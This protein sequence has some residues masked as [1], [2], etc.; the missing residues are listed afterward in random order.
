MELDTE[1]VNKLT[2]FID[3]SK[4]H[5]DYELEV[6]LMGKNFQKVEIDYE[7]YLR[8]FRKLTYSTDKN[9]LGLEY[10]IVQILDII[11]QSESNSSS[12]FD[13]IR[14]SI[15]GQD[16]I[17]KYWLLDDL[18]KC[19]ESKIKMIEKE[20]LDKIDERNYHVR[21][22]LNRE[23]DESEI[24]Q[25]NKNLIMNKNISKDVIKT[26]RLKNRYS[27][28]TSDGLFSIDMTAIKTGRGKNLKESNTMKSIPQFEIEIEFIGKDSSLDNRDICY[29]CI[30]YTS[31]LLST[32]QN[33]ENIIK[34][35]TVDLILQKY[36]QLVNRRRDRNHPENLD[37]IA[38]N[39]VTFHRSNLIQDPVRINIY[40]NYAVTLKA[41]GER[42]L[43]Y[44]LPSDNENENGKMYLFDTN[45]RM[46]DTG[47]KNTFWNDTLIEGEL[48]KIENRY[49]FFAYDMLF[50]RGNDIRNQ[51]LTEMRTKDTKKRDDTRVYTRLGSLRNFVNPTHM[52]YSEN[53]N[54]NNCI[55]IQMKPYRFLF[56]EKGREENIFQGIRNLWE[57]RERE[58][59]KSD[60]LIFTPIQ[61][62]YPTRGGSWYHL[63]KWKPPHLN[64]IDFLMRTIKN[65]QGKELRIPH[66]GAMMRPNGSMDT[67]LRQYK[68]VKLYVGSTEKTRNGKIRYY[69]VEFNPDRVNTDASSAY[70]V[71]H[72]LLNDDD[73]MI[74]I[75]P[76]HEV[77]EFLE[78]DIVVEFGYDI[79]ADDGF[80]WKPYRFRKDKTI[81]YRSGKKVANAER[82][83]N[84]V[85]NAIRYPVTEEMLLTGKVPLSDSESGTIQAIEP[86]TT[87]F[88]GINDE[89]SNHERLPYQ[90]FHN[91]Y[92]KYMLYYG[93]SPAVIEGISGTKGK[94]LDLC[95]GKGVDMNKIAKAKYRD[96][97]GIEY[98]RA[99]VKKAIELYHQVLSQKPQRAFFMQG[100][101]TK[102]IFPEQ[103]CGITQADKIKMKQ[104]IPTKYMFDTISLM[105]CVHY[106]FKDE[107]S[108]RTVLQ[109][110]NDNLKIG[111]FVIGTTFDGERIY[112]SLKGKK[113]VEG[114]KKDD[115]MMWRIEK[116]YTTRL[117][118]SDGKPIYGKKIDV[119]VK[120]I[121]NVHPEY[122]VSFPFFD[123]MLQEYGFEKVY[124]KSFQEFYEELEAATSVEGLD[125]YNLEKDKDTIS[126]MSE[127]EKR[128]SFFSNAFVYR[129]VRN[130]PDILYSKL[131]QLMERQD[132]KTISENVSYT[133]VSPSTELVIQD[134]EE[135]ESEETKMGEEGGML[136]AHFGTHT[137][138]P[139]T[140]PF[141]SHNFSFPF[142]LLFPP[143][144]HLGGSDKL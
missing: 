32:I 44:V 90:N 2:F 52:Q 35:E 46:I 137:P 102:L 95:S 7:S 119:F 108:L 82:T 133:M 58:P 112:E 78:D 73:K 144:P 94:I 139:P 80:K 65:E 130:T 138:T 83:A 56:Y 84:D 24:N 106:F 25:K 8:V 68:P 51:P 64:T 50:Y 5:K 87:Y 135:K 107:I 110:L 27:I 122:L 23:R 59:F 96:L 113:M 104:I 34:Q 16:E 88:A 67:V 30:S 1:T 55:M 114:K 86:P 41:D 116:K 98:D 76:L 91:H 101:A 12:N 14:L 62:P 69:P 54:E 121:G 43:L 109:N 42:H 77:E 127:D 9:G 128:W 10:K 13:N 140:P 70:N 15:D 53:F 118:F 57:N 143:S 105:F 93:T 134:M 117:S 85:F 120:S 6:R 21:F 132:K 11:V 38:A 92:I 49:H 142:L 141:F 37:F 75:D 103:S 17:K 3:E 63:L 47:Y 72:I 60:G 33:N 19:D 131:V 31:F 97:V 36:S 61:E 18:S 20:K 40:Q 74:A 22:S 79:Q 115:S 100:D 129:K 126:K 71:T 26:Y 123:R 39:P 111:G 125:E 45:F 81:M 66:I 136:E 29:K 124:V 4:K 48:I 99:G 28:T 89:N